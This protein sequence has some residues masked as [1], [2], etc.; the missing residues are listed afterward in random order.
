MAAMRGRQKNQEINPPG[1]RWQIIYCSFALIL[2]VFFVMILSHS[3]ISRQGVAVVQQQ[4]SVSNIPRSPDLPSLS[5][6]QEQEDMP[7]GIL[8][9]AARQLNLDRVATLK[10]TSAGIDVVL[11]GHILFSG[12]ERDVEKQIFPYLNVIGDLIAKNGFSLRI[13]VYNVLPAEEANDDAPVGQTSW[14]QAAYRAINV[15]QFFLAH[16]RL[17]PAQVTASGF[18]SRESLSPGDHTGNQGRVELHL[19]VRDNR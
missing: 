12:D 15:M 11:P 16:G 3:V 9:D 14:E 17:S 13:R 8:R 5:S 1:Q 7:V 4:F 10:M 2:V 6:L 18:V 19:A